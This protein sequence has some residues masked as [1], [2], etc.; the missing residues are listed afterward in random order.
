VRWSIFLI[1]IISAIELVL[2]KFCA[3][4]SIAVVQHSTPVFDAFRES[5][6]TP[7]SVFT[8][9]FAGNY[10]MRGSCDPMHSADVRLHPLRIA[11]GIL[12]PI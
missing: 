6:M 9:R 10:L 8:A 7:P 11:A 4:I 3:D 1:V 5:F 12:T 2:F